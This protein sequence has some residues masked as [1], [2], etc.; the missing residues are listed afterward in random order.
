N[1]FIEKSLFLGLGLLNAVVTLG[2]FV[3]ILWVLSASAPFTLFGIN[4]A[5]PGYLVWAALIYSV[6]GTVITQWIGRTLIGLNFMQ[7]RYEA[8]FRYNLVR[9]R[10]N[11]EQIALLEGEPAEKQRL[12][13]RFARLVTNWMAIMSRTKG[14]TF[15][16]SGFSQISTVFP[17]AVVS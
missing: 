17:Y 15:F 10:E 4:W 8:D 7:Q 16:T 1:L 13:D 12:L 5:I 9:V 3:A 11:S 14:L 2:S 6:L